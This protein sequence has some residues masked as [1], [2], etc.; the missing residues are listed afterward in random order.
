MLYSRS[1]LVIFFIIFF[2]W[3]IVAL[4]CCVSFCYTAKRI[5]H[6]Y[7]KSLTLEPLLLTLCC[8][9]PSTPTT[10]SGCPD[11]RCHCHPPF[12][13]RAFSPGSSPPTR[14]MAAGVFFLT[15]VG[16]TELSL[17]A[18]PDPVCVDVK[19][20]HPPPHPESLVPPQTRLTFLLHL[21]HLGPFPC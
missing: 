17:S 3:S 7:T 4:H 10:A 16:L 6:T 5:I 15:L 1:L 13:F 19:R 11:T 2:Y 14:N 12:F 9:P 8:I 18:S 20:S 21:S